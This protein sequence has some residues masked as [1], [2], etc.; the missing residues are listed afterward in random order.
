MDFNSL[1]K[2]ASPE[3]IDLLKK[4]LVYDPEERITVDG[5]M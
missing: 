3:C 2:K 1:F 5:V 4:M